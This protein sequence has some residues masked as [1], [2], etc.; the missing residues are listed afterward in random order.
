MPY[1]RFFSQETELA[2][3]PQDIVGKYPKGHNQRITGKLSAG[4]TLKI[5]I[6]FELTVEL[7][8][9]GMILI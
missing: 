9:Q 4:Q 2:N 1:G 8:A 7:F 3:K 5:K 6:G